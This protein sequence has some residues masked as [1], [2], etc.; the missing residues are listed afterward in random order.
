MA[1]ITIRRSGDGQHWAELIADMGGGAHAPVAGRYAAQV[2][3][4]QQAT[5]KIGRA[6]V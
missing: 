5:V 4:A 2:T 3:P 6:H 1:D